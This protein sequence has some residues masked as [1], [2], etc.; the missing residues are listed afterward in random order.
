[1]QSVVGS[2]Y[3][4]IFQQRRTVLFDNPWIPVAQKKFGQNIRRSQV[5]YLL[6]NIL[7]GETRLQIPME[8]IQFGMIAMQLKTHYLIRSLRKVFWEDLVVGAVFKVLY[9]LRLCNGEGRR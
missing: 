7:L 1:M 6:I 8:P 9:N 2:Y 5:F 4:I 3:P